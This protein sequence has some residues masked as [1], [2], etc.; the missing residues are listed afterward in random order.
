[1]KTLAVFVVYLDVDESDFHGRRPVAV[2]DVLEQQSE[3][4]ARTLAGVCKQSKEVASAQTVVSYVTPITGD[5]GETWGRQRRKEQGALSHVAMS[6]VK[7][8]LLEHD[9]KA[10]DEPIGSTG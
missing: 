4:W 3:E 8:A 7:L 9:W 10:A 1:M 6:P 2:L 5:V